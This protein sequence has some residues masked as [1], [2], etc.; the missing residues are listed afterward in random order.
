MFWESRHIPPV[1]GQSVRQHILNIRP[2]LEPLLFLASYELPCFLEA[3]SPVLTFQ[4]EAWNLVIWWR[5]TFSS[6][7]PISLLN[8]NHVYRV[9]GK[10]RVILTA[11]LFFSTKVHLHLEWSLPPT[12]RAKAQI[13]PTKHNKVKQNK[14][15]TSTTSSGPTKNKRKKQKTKDLMVCQSGENTALPGWA[16]K[17]ALPPCLSQCGEAPW[18]GRWRVLTSALVQNMLLKPGSISR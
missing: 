1:R 12:R 7:M 10:G 16:A 2:C 15:Q 5:C 14:S 8:L 3:A 4:K 6:S 17:M 9:W 13:L 11:A 18:D